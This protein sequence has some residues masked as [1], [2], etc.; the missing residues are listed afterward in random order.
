VDHEESR[1]FCADLT[2][3][4][5][6]SQA[7]SLHALAVEKF[8]HSHAEVAKGVGVIGAAK[9]FAEKSLREE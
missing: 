1:S 4:R 5:E 7:G 6:T 9:T 2:L 8:C 3:P